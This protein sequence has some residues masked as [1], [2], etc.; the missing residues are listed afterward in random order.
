MWSSRHL[1]IFQSHPVGRGPDF[2][3]GAFNINGQSPLV[4]HFMRMRRLENEAGTNIRVQRTQMRNPPPYPFKIIKFMF[5]MVSKIRK[6]KISF[7]SNTI[8]VLL[9]SF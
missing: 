6:I 5:F 1:V 3:K 4:A 8:V 2:V 9:F 7:Q